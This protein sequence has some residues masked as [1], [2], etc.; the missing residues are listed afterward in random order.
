MAMSVSDLKPHPTKPIKTRWRVIRSPIPVPE[1]VP[2]LERLRAAEPRS[3]AGMPPVLWHEAQG[4]LVRDPYGNQWIDLT[5]GIVVANAGHAHPRILEAIRKAADAKLLFTYVFPSRRRLELLEKLVSLSPIAESKAVLF[6]SGTEATECAMML[7]RRH[8]RAQSPSKVGIVSF[9]N[10]FHGRTLGA[11]FASGGSRAADWIRRDL[12]CHYQ[13]PFPFCPR[14]PWG[15]DGHEACGEWC[16]E[17]CLD[18]LR[19]RGIG[20]ERI[21]GVI[22]EA[23]PGWATRPVPADFAQ[24]LVRWA[25]RHDILLTFDEVQSG[26]G[27]TGTFFSFEHVGVAPDLIALGKGLTSSLPVSALI[28]RA[29]LMDGP[30]PGEMS[31]THGG[32]PL[33]A[34]AALANLRVIEDERL[35][36]KSANL[37]A[38]V[39]RELE[40]LAEEFPEHFFSVQ[41][42]GLFI[43]AHLKKPREEVADVALADAVAFEAVRRGVMMFATGRG[44]LKVAP[45]LSIE[46]GAALEAVGVVRECFVEVK[47]QAG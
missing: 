27:R 43:S 12:V 22:A 5:S 23:V 14:C 4:F 35:T 24:A 6:S 15:R 25:A 18:S 40:R 32:N 7:M 45:P 41:G 10:S 39:K 31:S 20:P 3:M 33:C 16:F 19:E 8:G 36:E 30:L 9:E 37:G 44:Y 42:E 46:P 29:E 47:D 2:I 1:S 26:C 17:K 11:S 38:V 13:L 21:A 28:G 34:A